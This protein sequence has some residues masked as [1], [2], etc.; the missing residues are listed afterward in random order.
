MM[1]GTVNWFVDLKAEGVRFIS[2]SQGGEDNFVHQPHIRSGRLLEFQRQ[3]GC[4][5]SPLLRLLVQGIQLYR[6][7]KEQ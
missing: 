6:T 7:I 1:S 3:K 5:V 4:S 2:L